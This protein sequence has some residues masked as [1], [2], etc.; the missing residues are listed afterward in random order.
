M[1][2]ITDIL[3]EKGGL[4]KKAYA[5]L[6]SFKRDVENFYGSELN[7]LVIFGSRARMQARSGSDIDVAVI[8]NRN[9]ID[10]GTGR[11]LSRLAYPYLLKGTPISAL[12]MPK[13]LKKLAS[14]SL[15]AHNILHEG[16]RVI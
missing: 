9:D 1:E 13:N 7:S 10:S 14:H 11:Q 6:L 5:H 12:A 2:Q 4:T 16:R 3:G 15:L 8:L